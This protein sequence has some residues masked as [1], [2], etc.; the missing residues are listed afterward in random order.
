MN[1]SL[2]PSDASEGRAASWSLIA[3]VGL[4]L[5]AFGVTGICVHECGTIAGMDAYY[6][7][8]LGG[9]P[10]PLATQWVIHYRTGFLI[11][12][13]FIPGAALATFLQRDHGLA[14]GTLVGL[15]LFGALHALFVHVMLR[16]PL[17]GTLMQSG[18]G[19]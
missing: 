2:S 17:A 1:D 3:R 4:I 9:K 10:L 12:A 6:A 11:A 7:E 15:I 14:I 18:T 16:M 5:A 19:P 13:F 8:L